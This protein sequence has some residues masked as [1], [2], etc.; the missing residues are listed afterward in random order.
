MMV[1]ARHRNAGVGQTPETLRVMRRND[2][3]RT[4]IQTALLAEGNLPLDD[5]HAHLC[6]DGAKSDDRLVG[7]VQRLD[8]AGV[9][10]R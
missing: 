3:A 9:G 2:V 1:V 6:A 5:L 8:V 10:R 7:F 4:G